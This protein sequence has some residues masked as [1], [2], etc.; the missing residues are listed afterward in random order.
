MSK[1][2]GTNGPEAGGRLGYVSALTELAWLASMVV[3]V[4]GIVDDEVSEEA[5]ARL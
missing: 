4:V 1:A 5:G 2:E 3:V